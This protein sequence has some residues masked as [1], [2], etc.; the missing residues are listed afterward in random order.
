MELFGIK[1]FFREAHKKTQEGSFPKSVP[2]DQ[3]FGLNQLEMRVYTPD[4]QL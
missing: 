4:P 2:V 1:N 3:L